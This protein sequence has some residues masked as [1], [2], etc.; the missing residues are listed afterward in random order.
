M[1]TGFVQ[2]W[3]WTEWATYP[4]HLFKTHEVYDLPGPASHSL[5]LSMVHMKLRCDLSSG[6]GSFLDI[7]R[8]DW[9]RS[10]FSLLHSVCSSSPLDPVVAMTDQFRVLF[11]KVTFS[12]AKF[13]LLFT[14]HKVWKWAGH[15]CLPPLSPCPLPPNRLGGKAHASS[16]GHPGIGFRSNHT[17]DFKKYT[18]M[19][20]M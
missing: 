11:K 5:M 16:A 3:R 4:L 17:N 6:K 13:R 19:E 12:D 2:T 18:L 15:T 20:T 8:H 14:F 7:Y 1:C 10:S 9:N